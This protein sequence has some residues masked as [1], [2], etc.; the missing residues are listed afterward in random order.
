MTK[1]LTDTISAKLKAD[2]ETD[3]A[4]KK[5]DLQKV[6]DSLKPKADRHDALQE[7]LTLFEELAHARLDEAIA[8]LPEAL[9]A[10]APDED[11][12]PIEKEKW[13]I[14]KAKPALAKLKK[15]GLDDDEDERDDDEEDVV[16]QATRKKREGTQRANAEVRQDAKDGRRNSQGL[17]IDGQLPPASVVSRRRRNGSSC[18]GWY[19]NDLHART[20][21]GNRSSP[22]FWPVRRWQG[23]I[24]ST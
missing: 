14:M 1:T 24:S 7:R 16:K 10:L 19:A 9:Q 22:V 18:K 2:M 8:E 23:A 13:L 6:I 5:G 20:D 15:A 4:A 17:Q 11:A 3:Q 21:K 12:D